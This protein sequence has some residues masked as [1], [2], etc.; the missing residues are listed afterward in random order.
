[1][2]PLLST[3]HGQDGS[4]VKGTPLRALFEDLP[5]AYISITARLSRKYQQTAPLSNN[6][7]LLPVPVALREA[8]SR[9]EEVR[10]TEHSTLNVVDATSSSLPVSSSFGQRLSQ[11]FRSKKAGHGQGSSNIEA[12]I[13]LKSTVPSTQDHLGLHGAKNRVMRDSVDDVKNEVEL[14]RANQLSFTSEANPGQ[15]YYNDKRSYAP[16]SRKQ[17]RLADTASLN[18]PKGTSPS[19]YLILDAYNYNPAESNDDLR[20]SSRQSESQML[21]HPA[22]Q[23]ILKADSTIGDIIEKYNR[24]HHSYSVQQES[25]TDDCRNYSTGK[26][27]KEFQTLERPVLRPTTSGLSQFDFDLDRKSHSS[28]FEQAEP[29]RTR[30]LCAATIR[31]FGVDPGVGPSV[32]LPLDPSMRLGP[33]AHGFGPCSFSSFS[34]NPSW[35][36]SYGET[37][38]LLVA[39]RHFPSVES[40]RDTA[41]HRHCAVISRLERG[42]RRTR[43]GDSPRRSNT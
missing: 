39:F 10:L 6:L 25:A 29:L 36:S 30:D 32:L 15:H 3:T 33:P 38:N 43:L 40:S 27:P 4:R 14:G 5:S 9:F 20:S 1:M 12:E 28:G 26:L 19:S 8:P 31:A 23:P 21:P 37:N 7:P 18:S 17:S 22:S 41:A 35:A 2:T 16:S 13:P 34:D 24:S 11:V 42:S